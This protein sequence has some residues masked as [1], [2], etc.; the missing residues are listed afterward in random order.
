MEKILFNIGTFFNTIDLQLSYNQE[1]WLALAS[2]QRKLA[3]RF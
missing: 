2:F 1:F 3:K